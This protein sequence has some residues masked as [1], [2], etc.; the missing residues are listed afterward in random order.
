MTTASQPMDKRMLRTREAIRCALL[1]LLN[2]KDASQINV[3]ELTEK[4]QI[5]RKT[6]YLHYAS[7]DEALQELENEIEGWVMAQLAQSDIWDNRHDLYTILSRVDKALQ[8][9]ETYSCYL[10]NR[11]SRYFLMYRLKNSI[12]KM[13]K[14]EITENAGAEVGE[15]DVEAAA[16]FAVSGVLSMYLADGPAGNAAA[17]GREGAEAAD[18]R[19]KRPFGEKDR[20]KGVTTNGRAV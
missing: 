5:S 1:S 3:S 2:Q 12:A 17:D 20:R 16:D 8:E 6:F 14:D 9:H 18:R 15:E 4:A 7:V 11:R 10:E 19:G 13:V